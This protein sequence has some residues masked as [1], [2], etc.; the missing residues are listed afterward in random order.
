MKKLYIFAL[1]LALLVLVA[2]SDNLFGSSSSGNSD[3]GKDI[4]CL[5]LDAENTF[6]EG[7]YQKSYDI[8]S[9]IVEIDSTVS[10]GY[11]G[12]AKASLWLREINPLGI[13]SLVKTEKDECPFMG[14]DMRVQNNYLQAM[15]NI[16]PVLSS[17]DRRDSLTALYEFHKRDS[18]SRATNGRGFDTTFIIKV[19]KD[20]IS[21]D[22]VK[23]SLEERLM[24]FREVFCGNSSIGACFDTTQGKKSFPLS[25]REYKSSYFGGIL[26]LSSFSKAVLNIFDTNNDG[27]LTRR[28]TDSIDFPKDS[29]WGKWGCVG[30]PD[31]DLPISLK[32]PKDENGKMQVII[33]SE[34]ILGELQKE[35]GDYYDCVATNPETCAVPDGV[36]DINKTIDNFDGDFKEVENVLGGLGLTTSEDPD[37]PSLKDEIDKYKAYASFYKLGSHIDEDGDGC[38]DEELLDGLDNDGD[39]FISENARLSPI[40]PNDLFWG[41]GAMN[42]SMWGNNLYA[43]A[44]NK[45]YNEPRRLRPPVRIYNSPDYD[46]GSY[47]ELSPD[48]DGFVT[49]IGFTQE[50]YPNGDKY[51]TSRDMEL[52]LKVAQDKKCTNPEFGSSLEEHLEYRIKK[53]GGCWPYYNI[54]KFKKY[55]TGVP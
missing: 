23:V 37:S 30:N 40:D 17:L 33:D 6:R 43:D 12:M 22:T 14:E 35:L 16:I 52:K 48:P 45:K 5:R 50:G 8:C 11:F 25:D 1:C 9:K 55:C 7:K 20:G 36:K 49:V 51:W 18:L 4:K 19:I 54:E 15:K 46:Y 41:I 34:Q 21:N 31:Y 29:E 53:I 27:C 13:F 10:F 32:C 44:E 42:S 2:C 38:V 28:G 39:G 47:T 26:L 3:C 24:D